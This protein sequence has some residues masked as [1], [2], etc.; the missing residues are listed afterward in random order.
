MCAAGVRARQQGVVFACSDGAGPFQEI[1]NAASGLVGKRVSLDVQATGQV[2]Y[3]V[4]T[5]HYPL[6]TIHY[7]L[8]TIHYPLSTVHSS[9]FTIH[10]PLFTIRRARWWGS[11]SLSTRR[12]PAR[13]TPAV[14]SCHATFVAIATSIYDQYSVG[15]SIR[16][17]CTRCC[18]TKTNMIQ[19][20]SNFR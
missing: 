9:L 6:S 3:P 16:P 8:S 18:L 2:P 11:G 19:V 1:K 7:S 10:Y 15:S 12:P 20:S 17:I 5:V 14:S 13:R 4:P